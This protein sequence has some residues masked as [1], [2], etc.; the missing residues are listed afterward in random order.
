MTFEQML[1]ALVAEARA[2]LDNPAYW[3]KWTQ[4]EDAPTILHEPEEDYFNIDFGEPSPVYMAKTYTEAEVREAKAQ[5]LQEA[6]SLVA[7]E[8]QHQWRR[9]SQRLPGAQIVAQRMQVLVRI[10]RARADAV[11]GEG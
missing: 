4:G 9:D 8:E 3:G 2:N 5:A 7:S 11:R 6:A 10:L 1:D